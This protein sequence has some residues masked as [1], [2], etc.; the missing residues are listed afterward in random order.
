MH[1]KK[2]KLCRLSSDS[3]VVGVLSPHPMPALSLFGVHT[4]EEWGKV[5][6][7]AAGFALS[8][9][10]ERF[11]FLHSQGYLPRAAGSFSGPEQTE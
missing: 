10:G 1:D 11:S 6:R 3:D 8:I 7:G 4:E 5:E 2:Q 9:E